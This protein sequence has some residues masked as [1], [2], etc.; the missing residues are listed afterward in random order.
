MARRWN[1]RGTTLFSAFLLNSLLYAIVATA[2]VETR[3]ALDVV[4]NAPLLTF[5]IGFLYSFTVCNIM[6][7]VLSYGSSLTATKYTVPYW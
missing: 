5:T 3:L 6:Y 7:V 4:A 2:I 1:L